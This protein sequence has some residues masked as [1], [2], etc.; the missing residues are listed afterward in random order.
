MR[1]RKNK[2]YK[3]I[4][5]KYKQDQRGI[6]LPLQEGNKKSDLPIRLKRIFILTNLDPRFERGNH[7]VRKTTQIILAL[8]GK[9]DIEL[10]NGFIKKKIR[11]DSFNKAI[12]VYP[13]V[14]RTLKNFSKDAL[15]LVLCDRKFNEKDYIRNYEDFIQQVRERVQKI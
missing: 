7:A 6:L 5:F 11:L 10:N 12:I 8:R 4:D 1:I 3:V 13:M 2:F 14:W 9:C 15:I